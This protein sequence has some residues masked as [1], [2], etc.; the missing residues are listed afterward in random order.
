MSNLRENL[1]PVYFFLGGRKPLDGGTPDMVQRTERQIWH[2]S[3]WGLL[4]GVVD[5]DWV[6]KQ[7]LR[8]RDVV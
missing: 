4:S 8:F 5:I 6:T 2:A 3:A 7:P 1:D